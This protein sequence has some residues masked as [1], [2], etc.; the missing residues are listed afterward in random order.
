MSRCKE[1]QVRQ[2]T[3]FSV[4]GSMGCRESPMAGSGLSDTTA[5]PWGSSGSERQRRLF[6]LDEDADCSSETRT[7]EGKTS[8]FRIR[9][10]NGP[11]GQADTTTEDAA[12]ER[13][14]PVEHSDNLARTRP[15][16]PSYFNGRFD[17]VWREIEAVQSST[18][19]R[20]YN[21]LIWSR[22]GGAVQDEDQLVPNSRR[23][24][25]QGKGPTSKETMNRAQLQVL[26]L[27]QEDVDIRRAKLAVTFPREGREHFVEVH[28]STFKA[29]RAAATVAL[30]IEGETLEQV[31]SAR[32]TRL[33]QI[34]ITVH[35][36]RPQRARE[37]WMEMRRKLEEQVESQHLWARRKEEEWTNGKQ[38]PLSSAGRK[39][40][41]STITLIGL[42]V[43]RPG[44]TARHVP[45]FI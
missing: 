32:P 14:E 13:L 17:Q 16:D 38:P 18:F 33:E 20:F 21:K 4:A 22:P 10:E 1:E 19:P 26:R 45:G 31:R 44:Y 9:L 15:L 41:E 42:A 30:R 34:L 8:L 12:P 6:G 29:F 36:V 24:R 7:V 37:L 3:F 2:P 39:T 28:F 35:Q 43:F 27:L 40:K 11:S 5:E 23:W 25:L